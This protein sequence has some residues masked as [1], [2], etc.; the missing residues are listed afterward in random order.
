M[1][2]MPRMR[3]KGQKIAYAILGKPANMEKEP[4]KSKKEKHIEHLLVFDE[5]SRVK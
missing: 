1:P 3:G 4:K 2:A 5:V